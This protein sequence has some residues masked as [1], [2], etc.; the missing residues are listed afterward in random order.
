[1]IPG[2]NLLASALTVISTQ[3]FQYLRFT[4]SAENAVG[5]D[6]HTF[7]D[8]VTVQGSVQ[9][10]DMRLYQSMGLDWDKRYIQIWTT[11]N[12]DDLGR[13]RPGDRVVWQGRLFDVVGE[14]DWHAIDG[15][16]SFLAIDIG[17][18]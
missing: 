11:Q 6:V 13:E 5:Q 1:M 14:M 7:A 4:G 3:P 12:I 10:V 16:N 15:W 8:A 17:T 9:A 18:P 2:S